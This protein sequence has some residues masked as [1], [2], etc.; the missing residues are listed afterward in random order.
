MR[1]TRTNEEDLLTPPAA[2]HTHA[3]GERDDG[4][5]AGGLHAHQARHAVDLQLGQEP[6]PR[7]SAHPAAARPFCSSCGPAALHGRHGGDGGDDRDD[8]QH[9]ALQ[10]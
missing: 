10:L 4:L 2:I 3:Q 5:H 6:I 9:G 7:P 1:C 8:G